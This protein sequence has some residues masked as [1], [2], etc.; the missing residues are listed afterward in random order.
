MIKQ[1][2]PAAIIL[3]IGAI[4]LVLGMCTGFYLNLE[5]QADGFTIVYPPFTHL[6]S[7]FG[8]SQQWLMSLVVDTVM[9]GC[10]TLV[11]AYSLRRLHVM[12]ALD[13]LLDGGDKVA[14]RK[15][16]RQLGELDHDLKAANYVFRVAGLISV[17]LV[18]TS[19][20]TRNPGSGWADPKNLL[21]LGMG[22][23]TPFMLAAT[24]YVFMKCV[25]NAITSTMDALDARRVAMEAAAAQSQGNEDAAPAVDSRGSDKNSFVPNKAKPGQQQQNR[26]HGAPVPPKPV[27]RTVAG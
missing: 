14:K 20:L 5:H 23:L 21:T 4:I 22:C 7:L 8:K 1:L 3:V 25:R 10:E 9:F 18:T 24:C 11:V 19:F 2:L 16:D 13:D 15:L 26:G 12:E 6:P 27:A 17:T